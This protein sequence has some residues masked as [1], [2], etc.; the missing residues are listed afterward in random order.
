MVRQGNQGNSYFMAFLTSLVEKYPDFIKNKFMF[1]ANPS[2]Y[3]CVKIFI[4]G[5]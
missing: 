1:R 2:R 5:K 3:Y 4:D